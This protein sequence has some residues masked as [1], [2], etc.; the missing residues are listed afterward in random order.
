MAEN[1]WKKR[2]GV[3]FSTNPD[4]QYEEEAVSE[5]ETL[6]VEKLDLFMG[7]NANIA[8]L[9]FA[10]LYKISQTNKFSCLGFLLFL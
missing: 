8:L 3:V 2:L 10:I 7:I 9:G 4:F 1:D 5:P 6:E